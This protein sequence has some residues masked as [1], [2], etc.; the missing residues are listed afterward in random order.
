VSVSLNGR[1]F[2][3]PVVVARVPAGGK[4]PFI[5]KQSGERGGL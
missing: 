3:G 5:L 2:S 1:K 4:D